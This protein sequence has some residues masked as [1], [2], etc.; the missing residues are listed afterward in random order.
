M[1]RRRE[2]V[3]E[4]CDVN[5]TLKRRDRK[6]RLKTAS[7]INVR[8]GSPVQ[9]EIINIETVSANDF[10][11]KRA[12]SVQRPNI[13]DDRNLGVVNEDE[14]ILSFGRRRSNTVGCNRSSN[15][16]GIVWLC[17]LIIR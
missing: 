17:R 3:A 11:R 7:P 8:F 14:E 12:M 10:F 1:F 16:D 5:T 4:F 9:T 13:P 15:Y 6:S 2:G